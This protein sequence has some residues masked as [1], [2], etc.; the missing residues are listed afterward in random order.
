MK[1]KVLELIGQMLRTGNQCVLFPHIDQKRYVFDLLVLI[2][3]GAERSR[4]YS[5][6]TG[7]DKGIFLTHMQCAAP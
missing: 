4:G 5:G 7:A 1:I 2:P 3:L 6:D